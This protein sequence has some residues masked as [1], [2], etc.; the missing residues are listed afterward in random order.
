MFKNEVKIYSWWY[1]SMVEH[2]PSMHAALHSLPDAIEKKRKE[3][4]GGK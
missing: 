4:K 1:S 2:L 3:G